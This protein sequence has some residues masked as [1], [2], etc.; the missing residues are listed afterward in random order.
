MD[1]PPTGPLRGGGRVCDASPFLFEERPPHC[2]LRAFLSPDDQ[3]PWFY[4]KAGIVEKSTEL[5]WFWT[6]MGHWLIL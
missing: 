1:L 5:I 3:S 2:L 6:P 4:K